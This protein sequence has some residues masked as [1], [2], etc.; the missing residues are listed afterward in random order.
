M[1]DYQDYL[2]ECNHDRELMVCT[3][4]G[5]TKQRKPIKERRFNRLRDGIQSKLDTESYQTKEEAK[6]DLE[7][8]VQKMDPVSFFLFRV[9][10]GWI[11]GKLLDIWW[12]NRN[13]K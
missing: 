1:I 6:A 3:G 9:I 5:K 2:S 4:S 13:A 12:A 10:I 8:H 7:L 11:L